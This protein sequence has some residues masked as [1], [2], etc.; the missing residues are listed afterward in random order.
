VTKS[1]HSKKFFFWVD[2][3]PSWNRRER[4]LRISGWC[5][6]RDGTPLTAIR[7]RVRGENF[8]AGL[9]RE[10]PEIAKYLGGS[11][12]SVHAG[13][14]IELKIPR[15]KTRLAFQAATTNGNW[16]EVFSR[17][18]HGAAIFGPDDL[19]HWQAVNAR[20]LYD[21]SIE[22]PVNWNEPVRMLY[23]VGWCVDR[24][25]APIKGIRARI[26]SR[27]IPTNYGIERPDVA[28]RYPNF[29]NARNSGFAIAAPVPGKASELTVEVQDEDCAWRPVFSQLIPGRPR[30]ATSEQL[31]APPAVEFFV[32][33]TTEK[34]RFQFWL[35]RPSDWSKRIR[36]LRVSGWCLTTSG[37]AITEL[38]GRIRGRIFP[39][40]Y[41]IRRPDVAKAFGGRPSALCSGFSLNAVVPRGPGTF[42]LEA[43]CGNSTW[44][45]FF[46]YRINGPVF[47]EDADIEGE[48]FGDY[49]TWIRKYDRLTRRDRRQIEQHIARFKER[50]V[51]SVLLPTYNSN[52]KWLGRAIESVRK[53]I[54]PNW[55]LCVADD[56]S[57]DANVWPA[58]QKF[59][60]RDRRIKILRRDKNG[61]IATASNDALS[62]A[63]GDFIAM[64]DH[65]DEL[66]P[67]ALY[68]VALELNRD[69]HLRFL[70]SDEDKLDRFGRRYDPHFKPDWSP[71]LFLSQNYTSH[72]SVYDSKLI[73]K[74]GGFRD[75]FEGAQDYD[76]TLRCVEQIN[77]SQIRRVP[78][79]LYHWRADESST[80]SSADAKPYARE[81]AL[82]A[83]QEH[84]DRK[85]IPASV[86]PN[87]SIYQH[88]KYKLPAEPPLVSIIIPTRDRVALLR[89]C[90][91]SILDKTDYPNYE[92]IILDNESSEAETQQ[93]LASLGT[94]DRV[95]VHAIDGPFNYSR[96]N[97]RGVEI[98]RGSFVALI[99]NDIEVID[100]SWLGELVGQSLRRDVGAVGARLRYPDGTIQHGGV[101]LGAGGIAGHAHSGIREEDGYFSRPHLVQNLSAVTAACVLIK[102]DAYLKVG[103]FDEADLP[104]AFNDVDFCLRLRQAGFRIVWT[105]H[106]ELYHHESASRGMEDTIAKQTRFLAETEYMRAKWSS[107]LEADPFY[108]PNLS[109]GER[110]FMPAF[111]PRLTKPWLGT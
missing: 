85:G 65:D 76:L 26:G 98:A 107:D 80:A 111:P 21:F 82:R 22:R 94:N 96:L 3:R 1:K 35:D 99:N 53:Q 100:D 92:I 77:A 54:Y 18:I 58:I 70:Y 72:L 36:Y 101:I 16:Q 62:L 24:S 97:N 9:D 8:Q 33:Y 106:A 32:P 83:V 43:R 104:V 46:Q 71:D 11:L 27:E 109:L 41:G 4:T 63:T 5:L 67:A 81:S 78:R 12:S 52:L 37:E 89:T 103:G 47:R 10:R 55:E 90:V 14:V 64:L 23:I 59:A 87:R 13:F 19:R 42:I 66:A 105:P 45:N 28:E 29:P 39:A 88:V 91:Q 75:G 51:I 110:L 31:F 49:P 69:P 2:P 15:R 40:R 61:G 17:T 102:R 44:E 30:S 60:R 95:V 56:A 38:R 74:V 6:A 108:N 7:A 93:Y 86:E 73:R 79:L 84:L 34:S 48:Q 20:V 68:Y 25:G 50:P 57:T